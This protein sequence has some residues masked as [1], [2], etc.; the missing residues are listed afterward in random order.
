MLLNKEAHRPAAA[1]SSSQ[2]AGWSESL[3][4]LAW[5]ELSWLHELN[6]FVLTVYKPAVSLFY[7]WSVVNTDLLA[8]MRSFEVSR[9]WSFFSTVVV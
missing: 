7:V 2:D 3:W 5:L 8:V 4:F 1:S 6:I 9:I